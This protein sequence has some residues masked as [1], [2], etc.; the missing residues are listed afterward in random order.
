MESK[1]PA[2]IN[3]KSVFVYTALIILLVLGV[4]LNRDFFSE[5]MQ[6]LAELS[7]LGIVIICVLG[8]LYRVLDGVFLYFLGREHSTQFSLCDGIVTAFCGSFFR[9]STLGSGMA[10]SKIYYMNRKG[11]EVGNG[12]GICFLQT[13]FFKSA[14]LVMGV[15]S[16]AVS[17]AS[18]AALSSMKVFVIIDIAANVILISAMIIIAV[19]KSLTAFLFCHAGRLCRRLS[20][21]PKLTVWLEKAQEQVALLQNESAVV[22]KNKKLVVILFLESVLMQ[23]LWYLTPYVPA[24]REGVSVID[25]FAITAIANML[26]GVIPAPSG[27]GSVELLFSLLYVHIGTSVMAAL[28]MIVYRFSSTFVPFFIGAVAVFIYRGKFNPDLKNKTE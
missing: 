20:R 7:I 22:M 27:F 4:L 23:A 12:M 14:I 1:K 28:S 11:I 6:G 10:V 18:V 26:A 24:Y 8:I 3:K 21:F 2:M 19:N 9:V 17:P 16:L 5:V 13:I 15:L 25:V